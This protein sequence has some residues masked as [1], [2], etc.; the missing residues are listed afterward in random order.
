[1]SL[2]KVLEEA[3]QKEFDKPPKLVYQQRKYLFS[4]PIWAENEYKIM[5]DINRIGFVLQIGYFKASGRFFKSETF[6][7]EDFLFVLKKLKFDNINFEDFKKGYEVIT[8]YRHRQVILD[9]FGILSFDQRQKELVFQEAL[10]L[11]KKQASPSKVFYALAGHIKS[12]RIEVPKYSTLASI[13]TEAVRKRDHLL[14]ELIKQHLTKETTEIFD[15]MLAL[16]EDTQDRTYLLT[17]LKRGQELMQ[18]A[19]IKSN[20]NDQKYLKII[21]KKLQP[22]LSVLDLSDDMIHYY[23][24]FVIRA[25]VFQVSRRENKYLML[26]CFVIYQYQN[27]NDLLIDTFLRAAQQFENAA[28]NEAKA[29]IY[30][31]H[32]E[33][34]QGVEDVLSMCLG[35]ADELTRVESV[36]LDFGKTLQEKAKFWGEWVNSEVFLKFKNS[37]K[38]VEKI[39]KGGNIKKDDAYFQVLEEKSRALQG[40]VSNIIKNID[41]ECKSPQ[42]QLAIDD[43]KQR[44]GNIGDKPVTSFLKKSEA[45]T[46]SRSTSSTSLYKVMLTQHIYTAMKSGHASCPDSFNYKDYSSYLIN[47]WQNFKADLME[48]YDVNWFSDWKSM[49]IGFKERLSKAYLRTFTSLNNGENKFVF[50]GKGGK[51]RFRE[52]ERQTEKLDLEFPKEGSIPII[53]ILNTLQE[54]T[55]FLDAFRHYSMKNNPKKPDKDL[56]FSGILAYGCN[57]GLRPMAI[58]VGTITANSLENTVNWY[59]SLENVRRANDIVIG[60]L[61]KLKIGELFKKDPSVV[62][63]SSDGQKFYVQVNSVH[64]NYGWKYFGKEKGIVALSFIDDMHRLFHSLTISST[65]REAL[66]VL[67]GLMQNEVVQSDMHSTDTHGTNAVNFGLLYLSKIKF[68]PRIEDFQSHNFYAFEDTFIPHLN[69]YNLKCEKTI[70]TSIIENNWD[71]ICQ[72]MTTI[73]SRHCSAS[74]LLKRLSSYTQQ[75]PVFQALKEFNKIIKTLNMLE[76]LDS[77]ELRKLIPGQLNKG[78][79]S[80]KFARAVSYE[81]GGEIKFA[82]KEEQLL[83]DACRRLIQNI[84]I[85]WNYLYL[86]D[87]VFKASPEEREKII[88]AIKESSPVH[89]MHVNLSG[90]F[91][92]STAALKDSLEF[93]IEKLFNFDWK[94]AKLEF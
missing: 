41:F 4:L 45:E 47:D 66:Y 68:I 67:E 3:Q 74:T 49:E 54:K 15:H 14:T 90:S 87:L 40:K 57:I 24:Q 7:K 85:A 38:T 21:Y 69:D 73:F 20:I 81:N 55:N 64:S 28:Q 93:D 84:I 60:M 77:E 52:N 33:N 86:S 36:T 5:F 2:I 72:F 19:A 78:E 18:S 44:N 56:F 82:S 51:P 79:N 8:I 37:K 27:I 29:L 91:D 89:W 31:N 22:L 88:K 46:L 42:L 75:H 17:Q 43:F 61:D 9:N 76:Y 65:E 70:N 11:F 50:S 59:F 48:K 63:T 39:R 94:E 83:S 6:Q 58:K 13:I 1:M 35:F 71:E 10:R 34:Q 12:H 23:A 30:Q 62:H 32:L 25:Q 80:N 26:L 53:Q 16:D 92:F